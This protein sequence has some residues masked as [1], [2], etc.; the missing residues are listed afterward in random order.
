M[1]IKKVDG[2][3]KHVGVIFNNNSGGDAAENALALQKILGIE[4]DELNPKQIDLF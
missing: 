2:V 3:T 4:P 1:T